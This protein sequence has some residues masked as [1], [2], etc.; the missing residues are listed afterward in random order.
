[1]TV[2]VAVAEEEGFAGGA[3]RLNMAA[4]SVTRAI[5]E[6]ER[7]LGVKLFNR[8]TRYVRMTE[9]GENYL[10]GCKLA[11]AA[12]DEADELAV[13][14]TAEPRGRLAL[15]ASVMFGRD[16]VMPCVVRYM[17][18]FP[19]VEVLALYTDRVVNLLE[20]GIDVAV[21]IGEL[22]DSSYKAAKV[23]VV[24]RVVCAAPA[25]LDAFGIPQRPRD[26]HEH[27]IV[28][29]QGLNPAAEFRFVEENQMRSV[30][31]NPRLVVSDNAAAIAATVSGIGISNFMSYQISSQ[32]ADG[33]LKI[34]LSEY[35]LSPV[36]V[37]VLHSEGRYTVAK[38]RSLIDMLTEDL[39]ADP[40]LN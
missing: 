5:A 40:A 3:R 30:K 39:R 12:A 20:E 23:G 10:R 22:P 29:P 33:S 8:T 16:Y 26:L 35:E 15:T 24:R 38:I 7:H 2:F 25:Y 11:I 14:A 4:P 13:G 18:R 1:M 36:P 31:V 19:A 27:Q 21:R 9:A 28:L 34:V 32:L 37:H 17:R 6:L